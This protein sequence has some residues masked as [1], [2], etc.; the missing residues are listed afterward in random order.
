MPGGGKIVIVSVS[1]VT[2]L[3]V[4]NVPSTVIPESCS[5]GS[6]TVEVV[7]VVTFP[8]DF[9]AEGATEGVSDPPVP[10]HAEIR[11]ASKSRAAPRMRSRETLV[12]I[13]LIKSVGCREQLSSKKRNYG[14]NKPT[15]SK[16]YASLSRTRFSRALA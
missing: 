16:L 6:V 14:S 8:D 4:G 11:L 7:D 12:N 13:R 10:P 9:G 3:A 1:E 15:F 5:V 2:I